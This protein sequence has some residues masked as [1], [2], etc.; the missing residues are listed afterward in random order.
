[1]DRTWY[2][3]DWHKVATTEDLLSVRIKQLA[4]R[5]QDIG[6]ATETLL[7]TRQRAV[8]DFMKRNHHRIRREPYAEGT[9][10]LLHETWLDKQHGNKGALRWAGPYMVSRA[11]DNGSYQIR[12]LDG[13]P[14]RSAV[15]GSRLRIYFYFRDELQT[16]RTSFVAE[17]ADGLWPSQISEP[18][19]EYTCNLVLHE[20]SPNWKTPYEQ[21][22]HRNHPTL[23]ELLTS[24]GDLA[25]GVQVACEDEEGL[26]CRRLV[27]VST[28][29]NI[30]ELLAKM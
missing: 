11:H 23:Q 9:W 30:C 26:P 3:L 16:L 14:L 22:P 1:M 17:Y 4:R 27:Q 21:R 8:D 7:K 12:E 28:R 19:Y 2:G 24:E 15:A 10:V 18:L 13:T 6:Q 5:E 20:R 25:L 29:T